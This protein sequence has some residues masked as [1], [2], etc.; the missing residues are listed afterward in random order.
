MTTKNA[1]QLNPTPGATDKPA[2]VSI[3]LHSK[4][5]TIGMS[6]QKKVSVTRGPT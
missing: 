6:P 5:P 3:A 4:L 1:K 2:K